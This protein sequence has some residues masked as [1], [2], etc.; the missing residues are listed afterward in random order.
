M[1]Y[2]PGLPDKDASGMKVLSQSAGDAE[3]DD[4]RFNAVLDEF[5]TLLHLAV[6]RA[7]PRDLGIQV[8]DVEQDAR[9]RLWQ[10]LQNEREIV[11]LAS[12]IYRIAAT[13]TIDAVRRVK[14]RREEQFAG[15][16]MADGRGTIADSVVSAGPSPEERAAEQ[17]L[18]RVV[19]G[20]LVRLAAKRRRAVG[21]H[22]QGMTPREV[23]RV[24]GWSEPKARNLVYRGLADLRRELRAMGIDYEPG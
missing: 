5:G 24:L 16:Q 22:L 9:I 8:A 15:S 2:N 20:A 12:Y 17:S 7:C 4:G 3:K 21:L 1:H 6:A 14:A 23:G 11:D 19:T 13:A 18:G 10:A